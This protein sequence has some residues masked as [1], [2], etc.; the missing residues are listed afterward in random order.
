MPMLAD[1]IL[2]AQQLLAQIKQLIASEDYH[3][4]TSVV[5]DW[6]K[7]L[8]HVFSQLEPSDKQ[9]LQ[10]VQQLSDDFAA[11]LPAL[12][13]EHIKIKHSISQIAAVK[14]DNKISKT[15]QID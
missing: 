14:S 13:Q 10:Q 2:Q 9:S 8:Q 1:D 7:L 5:S 4:A 3:Q 12:Q 11:L 6:Q 15:Y